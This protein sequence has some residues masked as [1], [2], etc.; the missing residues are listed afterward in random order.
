[1]KVANNGD[2]LKIRECRETHK[3]KW[4]HRLKNS[5]KVDFIG[6]QETW[7]A[8]CNNIDFD[9]VWVVQTMK[10]SLPSALNTFLLCQVDD[11]EFMFDMNKNDST[12]DSVKTTAIGFNKFIA[13]VG[14]KEFNLEANWTDIWYARISFFSNLSP[15]SLYCLVNTRITPY[16]S[17]I[18]QIKILAPSLLLFHLLDP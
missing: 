11:W 17:L 5:Q 16:W 3:I 6:L 1:M 4:V 13:D 7:V 2:G 18:H 8:D 14:L 10:L 9:G 15:L 12:P